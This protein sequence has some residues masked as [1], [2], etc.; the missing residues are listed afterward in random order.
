[1]LINYE[2]AMAIPHMMLLQVATMVGAN[3][4]VRILHV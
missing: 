1:V 2:V 3:G 4:N